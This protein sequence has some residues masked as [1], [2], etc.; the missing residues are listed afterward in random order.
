MP[1]LLA[2]GESDLLVP[3]KLLWAAGHQAGN[4]QVR[5]VAGAGHYLPEERPAEVARLVVELFAL[6]QP[7]PAPL[8]QPGA[9][10]LSIPRRSL[11]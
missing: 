3:P 1:A 5:I 2:T 6:R 8:G 9:V 4:P 10:G 11:S 7:D